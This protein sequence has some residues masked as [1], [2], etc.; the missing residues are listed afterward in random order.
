MQALQSHVVSVAFEI[1]HSSFM[2]YHSG[3]WDKSC[4]S[5]GGHAVAVVGYKKGYWIIRNSWGSTWGVEGHVYFK[6]GVNLCAIETWHTV[7]PDVSGGNTE[8]IVV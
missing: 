7:Y 6:K 5:G 3:V 4:G 1:G 8:R 2:S